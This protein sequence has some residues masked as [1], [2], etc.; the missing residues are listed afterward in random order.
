M[1]IEIGNSHGGVMKNQELQ[2]VSKIKDL[3]EVGALE[4]LR[5]EKATDMNLQLDVKI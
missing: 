3:K 5:D 1:L 2:N 4:D